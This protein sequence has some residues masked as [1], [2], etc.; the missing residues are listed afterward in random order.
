MPSFHIARRVWYGAISL[1]SV[2]LAGAGYSA[3]TQAQ[4]P[5]SLRPKPAA[6]AIVG[7]ATGPLLYVENDGSTPYNTYGV[8]GVAGVGP[9]AI[10]VLGYGANAAGPNLALTGFDVG[11]GSVA[12]VGDAVFPEPAGGPG[13]TATTG[14]LGIAPDG[15]GVMGQ[16]SVQTGCCPSASATSAY[17]GVVGV[18]NTNNFGYNAGVIGKTTNGSY[19]VEGIAG[20]GAYGGVE[21]IGTTSDGLN[22][23]STSAAGVFAQSTSG[24]GVHGISSSSE[25]VYGTSS[26]GSG[27]HGQS[28]SSYGVVAGSSSFDGLYATGGN[29]IDAVGTSRGVDASG[30]VAY[31]GQ[32]TN[33]GGL[34]LSLYSNTGASIAYIDNSGNL[35][36]AGSVSPLVA[37]RGGAVARTYVAK[38]TMQ[39]IEDFG[40]GA[41]VNGTGS[42][43]LDPAFAQ[44]I[45]G[46]GYQVFLTADGDN[47][48]LYVA[49]KTATGFVVRETQ[50][51]RSSLAFDYRIVAREYGHAAERTSVASS[52]TAFGA[53]RLGPSAAAPARPPLAEPRNRKTGAW[54][55]GPRDPFALPRVAAGLG[56]RLGH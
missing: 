16:T 56:Q 25:G 12:S 5:A 10:G 21:A 46:S 42:V 51:G 32:T 39:T 23:Y 1:A 24:I 54:D 52:A 6:T 44:T 17:A 55:H 53:P 33:A 15:D 43:R 28:T 48:G 29:A 3:S 38:S 41:I 8:L 20:S 18:D 50:G 27:V 26:S 34:A 35:A 37:T 40:S 13:S 11:P 31:Q 19:G 47:R 45:D 2:A 14:M 30:Y 4:L 7:N 36:L 9:L 49:Q 22:A